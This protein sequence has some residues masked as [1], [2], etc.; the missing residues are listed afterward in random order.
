MMPNVAEQFMSDTGEIFS[1]A[2]TSNNDEKIVKT[3]AC[4]PLPGADAEGD[5]TLISNNSHS[6]HTAEK[7]YDA[8]FLS[9]L[10]HLKA[11]QLRKKYRREATSHR[12][13]LSRS[14]KR[15]N[16]VHPV[17]RQFRNFLRLVGPM[18]AS[19][20]TLDRIDNNDREY[21]PGKVRWADKRTQNNNKGDTLIF[22]DLTTGETF[23]P[24][25][26][27]KLQGVSPSTI[28]KRLE[29]GWRDADIIAGRKS[30]RAQANYQSAPQTVQRAACFGPPPPPPRAMR[31]KSAKEIAFEREASSCREYRERFG[32]E[33]LPAPHYV[34]NELIDVPGVPKITYQNWLRKFARDW[35]ALRPHIIFENAEPYHQRAIAKIDPDYVR[36]ERAKI[37]QR[38]EVKTK[39]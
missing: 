33:Q 32:E 26:L 18:P 27:A 28:R 39:L 12:L 25:R 20:A 31:P 37:I 5:V 17:F 16:T 9:D 34:L 15:G 13:M 35:P 10:Q 11:M 4:A 29:R 19:R 24:S 21:A 23:T 6:C 14:K 22:H 30:E 3:P 1:H 8:D 7:F 36:R 2:A 38:E